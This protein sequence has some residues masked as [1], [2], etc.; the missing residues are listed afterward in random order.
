MKRNIQLF[1]SLIVSLALLATAA[2]CAVSQGGQGAMKSQDVKQGTMTAQSDGAVVSD[3]GD[4]RTAAAQAY[5]AGDKGNS[6]ASADGW[7][8]TATSTNVGDEGQAKATATDPFQE[9]ELDYSYSNEGSQARTVNKP[10]GAGKKA[11]ENVQKKNASS[12]SAKA[13]NERP[14][15]STAQVTDRV[16]DLDKLGGMRFRVKEMENWEEEVNNNVHPHI[17]PVRSEVEGGPE[18]VEH[19]SVEFYRL[20]PGAILFECVPAENNFVYGMW[21]VKSLGSHA[22]DP[23]QVG[24]LRSLIKGKTEQGHW[25]LGGYFYLTDMLVETDSPIAVAENPFDNKQERLQREKSNY[26]QIMDRLGDPTTKVAPQPDVQ[27]EARGEAVTSERQ[28]EVID[29]K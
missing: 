22:Y 25:V 11:L 5:N 27:S 2:G 3:Q 4:K 29:Q 6:L 16:F 7:K 18:D 17:A 13:V 10:E 1:L 21:A 20:N 24:A 9:G 12:T 28:K 19:K 23:M 26:Q 14:N 8:A 15:G